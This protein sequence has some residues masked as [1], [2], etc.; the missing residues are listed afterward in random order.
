[1][2][3]PTRVQYPFVG[4]VGPIGDKKSLGCPTRRLSQHPMGDRDFKTQDIKRV[5]LARR[6]GKGLRIAE[7]VGWCSPGGRGQQRRLGLVAHRTEN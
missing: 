5:S 7:T 2:K 3:P 4:R 1:M 6:G